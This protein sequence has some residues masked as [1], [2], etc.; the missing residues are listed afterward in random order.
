MLAEECGRPKF[1]NENSDFM[2]EEDFVEPLR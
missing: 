1:S 2:K